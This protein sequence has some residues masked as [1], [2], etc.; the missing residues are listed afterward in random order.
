MCYILSI[1][2]YS[3]IFNLVYKTHLLC[4]KIYSFQRKK[5]Q[6]EIKTNGEATARYEF[7][8]GREA[9]GL[10]CVNKRKFGSETNKKKMQ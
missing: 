4:L 10:G 1:N 3:D 2:V 5:N 9:G 8:R 7:R 6:S